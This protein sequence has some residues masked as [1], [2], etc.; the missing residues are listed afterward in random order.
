M[1][2]AVAP[3]AVK[4][5]TPNAVL[6]KPVVATGEHATISKSLTIKGEVSATE[7]LYIEGHVE[8]TIK[9][10][11]AATRVTVAR[12]AEVAADL[13]AREIFVMGKMRGNVVAGNRVEIHREGSLN[14]D[15]VTQRIL[16]EEGAFFKGSI[17]IRKAGQTNAKE[18]ES[19]AS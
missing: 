18:L 2:N 13:S 11:D 17:E 7:S 14:G 3:T 10:S 16:I 4:E 12:G 6:G 19:A 9:L 8:G 1:P 15:V 5:S